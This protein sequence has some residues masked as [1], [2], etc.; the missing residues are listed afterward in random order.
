[1]VPGEIFNIILA[2]A[3]RVV[4]GFPNNPYPAS[5]STVVVS[6]DILDPHHD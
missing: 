4:R 2:F 5:P 6:V 1:M 3:V